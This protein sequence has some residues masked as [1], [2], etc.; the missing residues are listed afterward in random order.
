MHILGI[1]TSCDE[2]AA[3]VV[4]DGNQ[5]R[6]NVVFSQAALHRP[7]GGVVPEIASRNHVTHFS[8]VLEDAISQS[9]LDW[10]HLDAIAVTYGPGL[11][12]SLL[13]GISAAKALA[14]RLNIPLV[15]INHLEA[16]MHSVFLS[17][18][19]PDFPD[20]CPFIALI[21]SGGHT[22]LIRVEGLDHYRLLGM[23]LDDAA[24]EAFDKGANLLGLGYPGGPAIETVS[25][26]G[27]P[28]AIP[29]PRGQVRKYA[30]KGGLQR[31]LCFSFSG[32]K[33]ALM[34]YM[35]ARSCGPKAMQ[36]PQSD[37]LANIAASFQ[38]AIVDVLVDRVFMALNREKVRCFSAVGGV[39]L[40]Q[41]L[42]EKLV[43]LAE[44]TG[45]RVF[46]SP[47]EYCIDNAAMVAGL[48]GTGQ[49]ISGESAWSLDACPNLEIGR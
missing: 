49:G 16:H 9:G 48:A 39:S 19:S 37:D 10:N 29:F 42:R 8:G 32:L 27:N 26:E 33:T 14:M 15:G 18:D 24:G 23:T 31:D 40:N 45:T 12:S 43:D 6:S 41:R 11:A 28:A 2:T 35:K 30:K 21:V 38:E 5:V 3:A 25:R 13:V 34:Y 47:P 46:L 17:P 22:C 20:I 1:E 7:Y 4:S 44:S 36:S